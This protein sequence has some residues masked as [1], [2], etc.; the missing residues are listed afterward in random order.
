MCVKSETGACIES[1]IPKAIRFQVG[2][3]FGIVHVFEPGFEQRPPQPGALVR[4]L[5]GKQCQ[6]S[7]KPV[8][9]S[10]REPPR[11]LAPAS[12]HSPALPVD[13]AQLRP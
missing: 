1:Q 13:A 3:R 10:G 5:D 8:W 12:D 11:D 4:R 7:V 2:H 9:P 6:V